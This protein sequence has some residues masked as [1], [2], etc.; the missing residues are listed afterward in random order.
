MIVSASYRTDIPA[1]YARWFLA[2]LAEGRAQAVNP[3]GG[4][5][6][7]VPLAGPAADGFVFWTRNV[8]PFEPALEAVAGRGLPFTVQFTVTGYPRALERSVAEPARAVEQIRRLAR[9]YGPRAAVWRY[10]PILF[11]DPTPPAFHYETFARLAAALAG[12]V[13][14]VTVSF[15]QIYRKTARNLSAAARRHG[16]SW[17]DPDPEEKRA[18]L[19]RLAPVA[20]DAGMRL[21]VCTQPGLSGHG[22][23][24][25]ACI[26]AARLSDVAGRPI[27][28]KRKGNRPGC[29]CAE[30]R[31]IG[32]Y[33][34]CPHGCVYCYAVQS[35]DRAAR[36]HRTH[37][38]HA[39]TLGPAP[40][41]GR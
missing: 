26:D 9:R 37:D 24:P 32:A 12:S 3:Y 14:E 2:R 34:T 1:F 20:A 25:A 41:G 17:R 4:K 11:A 35:R 16:F 7:E 38:R 10:D 39:P 31:D 36:A 28:A 6:Y 19:A 22:A 33:D 18:L 15:A 8:A 13:D 5:V 21:T 27:A 40:A 23:E 29:L 30:S